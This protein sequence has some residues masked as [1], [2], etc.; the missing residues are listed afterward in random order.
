MNTPNPTFVE[1]KFA[2]GQTINA[3][4][5]LYNGYTLMDVELEVIHRLYN[6]L[7][8]N[9]VPRPGQVVKIPLWTLGTNLI[10]YTNT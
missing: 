7:N 2:Q 9:Q 1:H 6:E 3:A 10:K 8:N 4:I 5:K